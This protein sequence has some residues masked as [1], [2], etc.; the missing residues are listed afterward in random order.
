MII[1]IPRL[2][3]KPS[4]S[5]FLPDFFSFPFIPL[6]HPSAE[7][8]P[9][10]T[11]FFFFFLEIISL[12]FQ[13]IWEQ[14]MQIPFFFHTKSPTNYCSGREVK[15]WGGISPNSFTQ[16]ELGLMLTYHNYLQPNHLLHHPILSQNSLIHQS[17][18]SLIHH[19]PS[20]P[21]AL[22]FTIFSS[23]VWTYSPWILPKPDIQHFF[24]YETLNWIR[25]INYQRTFH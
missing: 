5:A 3:Q 25:Q 12:I 6:N 19:V 24:S 15:P 7:Q 22:I 18:N 10:I 9:P 1:F 21:P 4:A 20:E 8:T 16:R 14:G 23:F 13:Q 2:L 17:Q 11:A